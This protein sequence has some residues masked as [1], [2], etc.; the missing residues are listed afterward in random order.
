MGMS[1]VFQSFYRAAMEAPC[2]KQE[3]SGEHK[4]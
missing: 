1:P 3:K 2:L 4:I